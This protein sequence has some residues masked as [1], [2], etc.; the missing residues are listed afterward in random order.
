MGVR[1]QVC[2]LLALCCLPLLAYSAYRGY[3]LS[4]TH[5]E[6]VSY[7]IVVGDPTWKGTANNHPLNTRLM[8]WGFELFGPKEWALRLPNVLSHLLYLSFGVML[9]R[10]LRS[11]WLALAGFA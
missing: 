1:R 9:L 8:K 3:R 10:S 6:S 11:G 5:D 7:T 4:F 2:A